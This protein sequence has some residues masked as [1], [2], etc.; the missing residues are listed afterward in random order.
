MIGK[1]GELGRDGDTV[2][3]MRREEEYKCAWKVI[4][5][6]EAS[7]DLATKFFYF[8]T[9]LML[10]LLTISILFPSS[11]NLTRQASTLHAALNDRSSA[12]KSQAC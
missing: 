5:R 9:D 6:E 7:N 2:V 8:R 3:S 11:P 1:E 12:A 4:H 10:A